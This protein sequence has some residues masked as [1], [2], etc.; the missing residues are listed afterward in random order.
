[1]SVPRVHLRLSTV[2]MPEFTLYY[3]N[4]V[5][6]SKGFLLF[7]LS[8]DMCK[9]GF[10]LCHP[11]VVHVLYTELLALHQHKYLSHTALFLRS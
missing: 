8:T 3:T 5:S 7:M 1:M 9:R 4:T 2:E 11:V 6:I 10:L